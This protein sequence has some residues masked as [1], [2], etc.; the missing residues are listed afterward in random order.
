MSRVNLVKFYSQPPHV[1]PACSCRS[2]AAKLE[3][4]QFDKPE[5]T[6]LYRQ[7]VEEY[8]TR[9]LRESGEDS[10]GRVGESAYFFYIEAFLQ[11]IAGAVRIWKR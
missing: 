11:M 10:F 8:P 2:L 6:K 4:K 3:E 5:A 9:P 7:I 1:P